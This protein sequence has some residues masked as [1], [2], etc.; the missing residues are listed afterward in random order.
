MRTSPHTHHP[1]VYLVAALFGLP[2]C[3]GEPD[4]P[5]AAPPTPPAAPPVEPAPA[6]AQPA[7]PS[8]GVPVTLTFAADEPAQVVSLALAPDGSAV[9]ATGWGKRVVVLPLD[10]APARALHTIGAGDLFEEEAIAWAHG[11]VAVGTYSSLFL[12][13]EDGSGVVEVAGR[14]PAVVA[15]G[16]GF[17]RTRGFGA[18]ELVA[19]DGTVGLS[20]PFDDVRALHATASALYALAVEEG[21]YRIVE[22]DPETLARRRTLP[23][24]NEGFAGADD[25]RL[26]VANGAGARLFQGAEAELGPVTAEG[27]SDDFVAFSLAGPLM[28]GIGFN[29]GVALFDLER[30]AMIAQAATENGEDIVL[31]GDR[32]VLAAGR[33][34]V[35]VLDIVRPTAP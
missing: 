23:A 9:A 27:F 5:A 20:A 22:L 8:L 12:V 13:A 14:T 19:A 28:A 15:H 4:A 32:R 25:G 30:R 29:R 3:G 31:D 26:V 16:E 17:A 35:Y 33:D 24:A 21:D 7:S 1:L 18:V 11:R 10:G 6:P 34:G 2:G